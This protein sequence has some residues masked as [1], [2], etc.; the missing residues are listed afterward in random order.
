MRTSGPEN[1]GASS[2]GVSAIAGAH[3]FG[4]W[5]LCVP[6]SVVANGVG[7]CKGSFIS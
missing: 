1:D 6:T 3:Q 4:T 7:E 5:G 2:A